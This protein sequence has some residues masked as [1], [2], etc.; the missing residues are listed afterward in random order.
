MCII[1]GVPYDG[2]PTDTIVTVHLA[3]TV[4]MVVAAAGGTLFT[5]VCLT[6]NMYF[7]KKR[8]FTK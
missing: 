3:V 6:Y 4:I 1:E 5:L 2:V 7:R 8:Y